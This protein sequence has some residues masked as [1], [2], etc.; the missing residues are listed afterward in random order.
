MHLLH[1]IVVLKLFEWSS[2]ESQ[3]SM[4]H[5]QVRPYC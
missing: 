1:L 5:L 4:E 2:Q 3:K